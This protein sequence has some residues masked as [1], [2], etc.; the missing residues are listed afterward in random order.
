MCLEVRSPL[1][2]RMV[3]GVAVPFPSVALE[4]VF[5]PSIPGLVY[6][7]RLRA[8]IK[9]TDI[10]LQIAKNMFPGWPLVPQTFRE[11]GTTYV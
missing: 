2:D 8:V 3:G 4:L 7:V 6:A 10:C 1:I 9:G 11:V 5:K